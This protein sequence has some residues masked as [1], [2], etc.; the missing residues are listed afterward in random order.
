MDTQPSLILITV[1][2]LR[3]DHVGFLGYSQHTTPFL[4]QLAQ[5]SLVFESAIVAGTP[6]YYSF[7]VMM[8]SRSPLALGRDVIGLAPEEPTLA[9]ALKQAG[10][11]T[12]AFV[13]GNPYLSRHFGYHRGFDLFHDFLEAEASVESSVVETLH[14]VENGKVPFQRRINHAFETIA[15]RWNPT[16]ALYN[17]LY[18][19]Y[20]H[21][22][23]TRRLPCR[24]DSLR[25]YPDADAI[26]KHA[27]T[28]LQDVG[29]QP[30]LLWLH[31][32]DP[33]HPYY[34]PEEALTAMERGDISAHQALY[35]NSMW[36]R[37]DVTPRR[38]ARY[39]RDV[40]TL[41]DAGI[42]WVDIQIAR[43]MESLKQQGLWDQAV[44]AV[45][46]DHGE[47][48]LEHGGRYHWPFKLV[49][50]IIRVP[51]LIHLPYQNTYS[52]V[53][54]PFSML[55]L[56]PTLLDTLGVPVP[57]EFQGHSLWSALQA[58][59]TL[60]EPVLT[61]CVYGCTNPWQRDARVGPRLLAVRDARYKLLLDFAN[62]LEYLFDLE[63]DPGEHNPLSD[64][65]QR[66]VRGRLLE[67][68]YEHLRR[69]KEQRDVRNRLRARLADIRH[70]LTQS[71]KPSS[72]AV[73]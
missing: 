70:Q 25:K 46:G 47:E 52:R 22:I 9:L 38:L 11:L 12:G 32:M 54:G 34:P 8:A 43:L 49:E 58:G 67:H 10:Y 23:N 30:F 20:C 14:D 48:F 41:Y 27:L 42:R 6:T 16:R 56:A 37:G 7:P 55:H 39:Q 73:S 2:C 63:V 61:E 68:A 62:R 28:W 64:S 33:H 17:E 36:N 45:T 57:D 26:V 66:P 71:T 50:E 53:G 4:D 31:L 40:V 21:W 5:K 29:H 1:D 15:T 3:A 19:H 65:E 72:D 44:F 18:F 59:Q 35:L 24:M 13:A 60:N 51:L 69:F